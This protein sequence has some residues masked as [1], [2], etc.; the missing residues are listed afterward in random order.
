MSFSLGYLSGRYFCYYLQHL[1]CQVNRRVYAVHVNVATVL[2]SLVF[3]TP[4]YLLTPANRTT[5]CATAALDPCSLYTCSLGSER[6][7]WH[8]QNNLGH[9]L[10]TGVKSVTWA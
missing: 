7:L 8:A 4:F 10:V 2:P 1:P 5:E 3:G 9:Q 6:R